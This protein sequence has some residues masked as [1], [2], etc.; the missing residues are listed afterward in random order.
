MSSMNK[1]IGLGRLGHDADVRSAPSGA[2]VM[3]FSMATDHTWRDSHGEIHPETEW[4]RIVYWARGAK[5]SHANLCR[6]MVKG[7]EVMVVGRI[8]THEWERDGE[9]IYRKEIIAETV[10][11]TGGRRDSAPDDDDDGTGG[12]RRNRRN[13]RRRRGGHGDGH[14]GERGTAPPEPPDPMD[15]DIE[16]I[17]I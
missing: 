12:D 9:K 14:R 1:W 7:P 13:R 8:R 11:L 5:K 17:P 2:E 15:P 6:Y 4:H 10:N 3:H 16:D